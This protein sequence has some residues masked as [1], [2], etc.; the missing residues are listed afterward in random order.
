MELGE[1]N[2]T[3]GKVCWCNLLKCFHITDKHARRLS[4]QMK[5]IR[6]I[7]SAFSYIDNWHGLMFFMQ[8]LKRSGYNAFWLRIPLFRSSSLSKL[9]MI[10]V[11]SLTKCKEKNE[12]IDTLHFIC[13]ASCISCPFITMPL[14]KST[15]NDHHSAIHIHSNDK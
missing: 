6:L 9:W 11:F 14:S 3:S 12:W 8:N 15:Q 5:Y 4:T 7:F 2:G 13:V 10:N 1:V